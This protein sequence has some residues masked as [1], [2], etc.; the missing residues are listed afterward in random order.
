MYALQQLF[1]LPFPNTVRKGNGKLPFVI[2]ELSCMHTLDNWVFKLD[3]KIKPIQTLFHDKLAFKHFLSHIFIIP[4]LIHEWII[5]WTQTQPEVVGLVL[6][7]QT[8]REHGQNQT[9][10]SFG[11]LATLNFLLL[12]GGLPDQVVHE[13]Y[14]IYDKVVV[15]HVMQSCSKEAG[16]RQVSKLLIDFAHGEDC[17]A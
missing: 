16:S 17:L 9:N 11:L 12:A 15:W 6:T 10:S 3:N 14:D 1:F 2:T 4:L 7:C 13:F 8:F 5:K